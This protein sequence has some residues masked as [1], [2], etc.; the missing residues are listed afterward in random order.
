MTD[1]QNGGD[2]ASPMSTCDT[3]AK[4]FPTPT[5]PDVIHKC[6][7]SG[8]MMIPNGPI[9]EVTQED[10]LAAAA[11][12]RHVMSQLSKKLKWSDDLIETT[13]KAI[14]AGR[15]DKDEAV[16]AFSRQRVRIERA[17]W[18][19]AWDVVRGTNADLCTTASN[20]YMNIVAA[21]R[22]KLDEAS[23]VLNG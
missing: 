15:W 10:R 8:G 11:Y 16:Q 17:I 9:R 6:T 12:Y 2:H 13:A 14:L 19:R 23:K 18:Y 20:A 3:C 5:R 22:K 1:C 7:C 21:V 4:S